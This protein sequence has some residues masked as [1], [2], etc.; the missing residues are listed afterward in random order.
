MMKAL[1]A[2]GGATF[3]AVPAIAVL[4]A[5]GVGGSTL[6]C[7]AASAGGP[8]ADAAPVPAAARD[9]VQTAKVACPHLPEAWIA[10]VMAQESGFRPEAHAEDSNGGTWG[11][12]Q[13]NNAIWTATY[14]DPWSADVNANGT[15]DVVEPEIHARVGGQYLCARLN[16]VREIRAQ[17][18]DWASS[19]LPILDALIIAHNAG[20]SRL[21]TYPDLPEITARFIADVDRRVAAWSA[22]TE[23]GAAPEPTGPAVLAGSSPTPMADA[24]SVGFTSLG[25]V[26]RLG[27]DGAVVVPPGTP[28]DVATAVQTAMSYVGVRSGWAQLCD[29][30]ACRAYG[31]IN[32]GYP[33]A[34][35]H[36]LDMVVTGRAHPGDECPPLGSFVFWNTGRPFG[37]VSVVVQADPGCD[38]AKTMVT[39]NEV[40][41]SASGN[42]GG[43]YLVSLAH[44]NAGYVNGRG[45]LGWSDPACK[46]ASLPAGTTHPAPP[47][48]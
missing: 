43:V 26:P 25:C 27:S 16:G 14:G 37:H 5:V 38:P 41:D 11:L 40:F 47:G 34:K 1:L 36:W 22:P 4:I 48:R 6:D 21:R 19:Q 10:A 12:F 35:A 15:W 17:H 46:G 18:P 39:A 33:S 8:L 42:H 23:A 7:L 44:L 2:G 24:P 9:W 45:Y 28:N 31:Y 3:L 20:E 29:R 32:S 13:I 30:L